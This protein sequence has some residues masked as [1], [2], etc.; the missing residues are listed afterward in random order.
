MY[1]FCTN[2]FIY[3]PFV[4]PF[5]LEI[6]VFIYCKVCVSNVCR[7]AIFFLHIYQYSNVIDTVL[8]VL[9]NLLLIVIIFAEA[10]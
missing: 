1:S 4:L 5:Y 6:H 3:V 2:V 9:I 7:M 8:I 10:C